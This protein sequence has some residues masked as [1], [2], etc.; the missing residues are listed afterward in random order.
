VRELQGSDVKIV[1]SCEEREITPLLR[2]AL[3]L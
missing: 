3:G 2:E 1:G